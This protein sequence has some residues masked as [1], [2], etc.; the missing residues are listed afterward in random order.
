MESLTAFFVI[1]FVG[2]FSGALLRKLHFP[3]VIALILGGIFIGPEFLDIFEPNYT[4]EFI[5]DVGLIFMMF[6][7]GLETKLDSF[8]ESSN[9]LLL[10][11]LINGFVPFLIGM[12]LGYVLGYK[13]VTILFMGVVYISSSVAIVIPTLEANNLFKFQIGRAVMT[14]SILQDVAS[15]IAL[16]FLL[17]KI[18]PVTDIPLYLFYPMMI[19]SL[20]IL[21]YSLP[22]IQEVLESVIVKKDLFQEELRAVFLI[23][24]G[25]ILIFELLGLHPIVGGFFVGLVLSDSISHD[26]LLGKIRAIGY[27]VFIPTFFVLVGLNTDLKIIFQ[28][29]NALFTVLLV[30]TSSILAKLLSG[31][32]GAKIVGYDNAK[33]LFFGASSVPQLSTTLAVSYTATTL[34]IIGPEINTAF[35]AL[36]IISTMVGPILMNR[37]DAKTL[38]AGVTETI[39]SKIG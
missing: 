25:T 23:L 27:G 8:K 29:E 24:F 18:S 33:A 39:A 35:V 10:L 31:Y 38:T 13:P 30:V 19:I 37:F 15:L 34:G 28:A 22:K 36:S 4:T 32:F 3:W 21:R 16:S 17:Q 2:L 7:A 11:A 20:I 14:T 12:S 9:K 5:G 1:I 6:M 26:V